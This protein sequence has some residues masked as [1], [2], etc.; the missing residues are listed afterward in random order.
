M[1][2]ECSRDTYL[3]RDFCRS[4]RSLPGQK[5]HVR[6]AERGTAFIPVVL[7]SSSNPN[8]WAQSRINRRNHII[9]K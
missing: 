6:C 7:Y 1:A 9:L 2:E 8:K 4:F 3:Q 5:S